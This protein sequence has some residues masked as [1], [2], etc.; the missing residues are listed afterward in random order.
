MPRGET[1]LSVEGRA[2]RGDLELFWNE[3]GIAV[4]NIVDVENYLR[5]V[6]PPEIGYLK[7]HEIEAVKAQTLAA[8]TYALRFVGRRVGKGFDLYATT[9]DQVYKGV[10][11]EDDVADIA[12]GETIGTVIVHGDSLIQAYFSACCGGRTAMREELWKKAGVPYLRSNWDTPGHVSVRDRAMCKHS[13]VFDWERSWTGKEFAGVLERWLLNYCEDPHP[14]KVGKLR[15][16]EVTKRGE[17]DRVV[18]LTIE[19]TTGK[20]RLFGD[21]CR[22]VLRDGASSGN[23]LRSTYFEVKLYG[24]PSPSQRIVV[25]GRG[26]GHGVGLCQEGAIG[27][28]RQG[29]TY[30]DIITHYY[31]GTRLVRLYGPAG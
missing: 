9:A 14:S 18:E 12:I 7:L 1:V 20:F 5:G 2:Y 26:F 6:V 19:T 13:S 21:N 29:Y 8:R 22:Y 24:S 3:G 23:L 30:D 31:P 28:A 27:M 16:M 10:E 4:A 17:S 15:N 25:T 11:A